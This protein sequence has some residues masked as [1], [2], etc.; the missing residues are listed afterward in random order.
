MDRANEYL[1]KKTTLVKEGFWKCE[2]AIGFNKSVSHAITPIPNYG[3]FKP[4][5]SLV[6]LSQ[7]R[8]VI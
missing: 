5:A 1:Q 8:L 6:R 3:V 2:H 4:L 7:K